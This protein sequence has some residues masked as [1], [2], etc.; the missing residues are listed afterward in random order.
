MERIFIK[1]EEEKAI[2]ISNASLHRGLW[3]PTCGDAVGRHDCSLIQ[4]C[5]ALSKDYALKDR[6][7]VWEHKRG[8]RSCLHRAGPQRC[9][10]SDSTSSLLWFNQGSQKSQLCCVKKRMVLKE[11]PTNLSPGTCH[12]PKPPQRLHAAAQ[13]LASCP[14]GAWKDFKGKG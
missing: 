4:R 12:V 10:S 7:P 6:Y 8:K 9:V 3:L 11:L 14:S 5:Q 13:W 2:L 1:P